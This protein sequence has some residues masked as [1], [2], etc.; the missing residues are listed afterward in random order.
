MSGGKISLACGIHCCP[1]FLLLLFPHQRLY[2]VKNILV[3]HE[4]ESTENLKNLHTIILQY[5]DQPRGLVVKVS[6]Y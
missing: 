3:L 2:F 6:A 1:R 5:L 4:G